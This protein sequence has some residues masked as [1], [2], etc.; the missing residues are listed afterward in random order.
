MKAPWLVT[1]D[2]VPEIE[3]LYQGNGRLGYS[4][5][6]SAADR[7]KGCEVMFFADSVSIPR[8]KS[9]TNISVETVDEVRLD[10]FLSASRRRQAH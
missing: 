6:Y 8:L 3:E 4:I 5:S 9:P 1:Y 2:A 7:Y 10:A